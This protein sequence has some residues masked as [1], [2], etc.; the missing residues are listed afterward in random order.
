VSQSLS[1]I[2]ID[3]PVRILTVADVPPDPNSGAAGTV[4]HTNS[5][6]RE[7]GHAVDEIWPKDLGMR[8]IAHGNLHSLIEQPRQY[9]KAVRRAFGVNDY[10]VVIAQQPQAWMAARDHRHMNRKS[11]FLTMSQGVETRIW[12]VLSHFRKVYGMP[13]GR[14]PNRLFTEPMQRLLARQWVLAARYSDGI[15]VQHTQDKEYVCR[16]YGIGNTRV[17]VSHSGL[18]PEFLKRPLC[19]MTPERMNRMLFVGQNAFYKGVHCLGEIVTTLLREFPQL[20]M[21]WVCAATDHDNARALFG[22][23]ILGR[24]KMLGWGSQQQLIDVLDNHGIFVFPT[25]AEG[26]AKAPLEAMSRG[27]VV[28][29]SDCCGMRDYISNDSGFLCTVGNNGEFVSAI[30]SLYEGVLRWP[31][32]QK[33]AKIASM[34]SWVI[35]AEQAVEFTKHLVLIG[36]EG[37]R[38]NQ[39]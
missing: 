22:S 32:S 35:S 9:V 10:D 30:R 20:S 37:Q 29:A 31:E 25:L 2:K 15:I 12:E 1:S 19:P 26:F 18:S 4:L 34:F 6:L 33:I 3:A 16:T 23:D 28:V 38:R 8:R 36:R 13:A 17:H 7:L 5:A 39:V 27:L 24:V 11:L 21:T 14:F